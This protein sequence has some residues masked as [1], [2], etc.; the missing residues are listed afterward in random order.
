M[1]A[2]SFEDVLTLVARGAYLTLTIAKSKTFQLSCQNSQPKANLD[3][4]IPDG[5]LEQSKQVMI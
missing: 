1:H 3:Q 5:A 2:R 4:S